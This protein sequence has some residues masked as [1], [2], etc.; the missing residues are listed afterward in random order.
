MMNEEIAHGMVCFFHQKKHSYLIFINLCRFFEL[1]R[2]VFS[3]TNETMVGST[4]L[5]KDPLYNTIYM[6]RTDSMQFYNPRF[7]ILSDW[8]STLLFMYRPFSKHMCTLCSSLSMYFLFYFV[9]LPL[10]PLNLSFNLFAAFRPFLNFHLFSLALLLP[11][12]RCTKH[13]HLMLKIRV[14]QMLQNCPV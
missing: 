12:M 11:V 14:Q 13:F 1:E 2:Y 9:S 10:K 6:V 4:D 5:R 3:Y 7:E 8:F